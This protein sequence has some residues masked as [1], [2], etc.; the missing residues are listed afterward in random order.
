MGDGAGG[1]EH[2]LDHGRGI[3]QIADA[4]GAGRGRMNEHHGAAA[5][6]L[7][8]HG[9]E[10]RIA[11]MRPLVVGQQHDAVGL[12][13]IERVGEF[14]Q[15]RLDIRQRQGGEQ[16]EARGVGADRLGSRLVHRA[17]EGA[18]RRAVAEMHAGRGDRQDRRRDVEPV[19]ARERSVHVPGG[20]RRHAVGLDLAG[21]HRGLAVEIGDE[22]SV[23]VDPAR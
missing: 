18:C 2:E 7:G 17:G 10:T 8:E 12:Q 14:G 3:G 16:A 21:R 19:H 23:H 20:P 13:G 22:V 6:E 4:G 5:I 15:A 9:L 11:E 1:L